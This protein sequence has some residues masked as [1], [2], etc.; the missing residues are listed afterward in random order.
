M[1]LIP[2]FFITDCLNESPASFGCLS[3][4]TGLSYDPVNLDCSYATTVNTL[5]MVFCALDSPSAILTLNLDGPGD[6]VTGLISIP[7]GYF[8]TMTSLQNLFGF[9][10]LFL[11]RF[12]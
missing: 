6:G 5:S 7:L 2:L 10:D 4:V 1:N 3:S 8:D 9:M 12:L 11:I